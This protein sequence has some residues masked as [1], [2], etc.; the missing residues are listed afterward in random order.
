MPESRLADS[1]PPARFKSGRRAP[2]VVGRPEPGDLAPFTG[3]AARNRPPGRGR[4]KSAQFSFVQSAQFSSDIDTASALWGTPA[5]IGGKS[6]GLVMATPAACA[7][8]VCAPEGCRRAGQCGAF[9]FMTARMRSRTPAAVTRLEGPHWPTPTRSILSV[10]SPT[11]AWPRWRCASVGKTRAADLVAGMGG[12]L[13]R[14]ARAHQHVA[15]GQAGY[16]DQAP[17]VARLGRTEKDGAVAA[18]TGAEAEA[19]C[20]CSTRHSIPA[21]CPNSR[22]TGCIR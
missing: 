4:S 19:F 15:R 16:A 6:P 13:G 20:P 2:G 1:A 18:G 22:V 9:R 10:W 14:G 8:L 7:G 11:R 3:R 12:H 5:A 21:I 17:G